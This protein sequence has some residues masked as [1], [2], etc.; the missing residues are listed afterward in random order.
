MNNKINNNHNQIVH[1]KINTYLTQLL[2][3][4]Y[5]QVHIEPIYDIPIYKPK[6]KIK[7]MKNLVLSAGGIRG[8]AHIGALYALNE[9]GMLHTIDT[10]A[11]TSVG[12][13]V[14]SL[15][16]VGYSPSEIYDFIR[17]FDMDKIKNVSILNIENYGLDSGSKMEYVIRKLISAKGL[18][19]DITL[20]EL[21]D[22]KKKK[23]IMAV[24]NVNAMDIEYISY[25]THPNLSLV[26]AIRMSTCIPF[27][28]TPISYNDCLYIDGGCI[29]DYPIHL[30][31]N[32]DETIG[33]YLIPTKNNIKVINGLD[34]YITRV[35]Y[36]IFEGMSFNS[37]TGYEKYTIDVH[38]ESI[39]SVDYDLNNHKKNEMF[40]KGYAAVIQ[41][42][43]I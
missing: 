6:T 28:Y 25:D 36:C 41:K 34:I 24:T 7:I 26:K 16:V 5:C 27:M 29:D 10:F 43:V 23:I 31:D 17:M 33:V 40:M 12:A 3:D 22:L 13:L 1:D 21:Y 20:K 39:N 8:I 14:V 42:F 11:G 35:M 2:G 18:A 38:L 32:L 15:Y 37:R 4:D 19:E 9:L 30:F